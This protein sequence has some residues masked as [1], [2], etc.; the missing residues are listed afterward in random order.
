MT[1]WT[2]Q[3]LICNIHHRL[4][5]RSKTM[6]YDCC[7]IAWLSPDVIVRWYY[8]PKPNYYTYTTI[9]SYDNIAMR[10]ATYRFDPYDRHNLFFTQ[11]SKNRFFAPQGRHVAPINVKFGMGERTESPLYRAKFHVYRGKNVGIQPPKL[12]KFRLMAINFP[13]SGHSFAQ[14]YEVLRFY[15]HLQVAFKF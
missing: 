6:G 13:L 1:C 10:W 3:P 14:F 12:S 9:Q 11:W 15:T 8:C 5:C 2:K 4:N 7:P